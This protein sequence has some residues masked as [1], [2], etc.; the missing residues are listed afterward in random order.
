VKTTVLLISCP[1]T[2]GIVADVAGWV[3]MNGGNIVHAEQH[4]D[5][6]DGAFF[7]RVEFTHAGQRDLNFFTTAFGPIAD[8]YA[9]AYSF[10]ELPW[11]PRTAILVSK[12]VH[13]L[14]DLLTRSRYGDL[15]LDIQAVISNHN[16]SRQLV[17]AFGYRYEHLGVNEAAT[18]EDKQAARADQESASRTSS[19][20]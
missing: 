16:D 19:T 5:H 11:R 10:H 3:A 17:E 8:K 20:H 2:S 7:Q 1:D 6:H 9:M 18:P 14:S 12:T 15:G 13:C 4:T